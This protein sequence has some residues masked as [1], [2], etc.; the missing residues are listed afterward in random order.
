MFKTF[1]SDGRKIG[2]PRPEAVQLGHRVL[3]HQPVRHHDF[4]QP[5][6]GAR[7]KSQ[8]AAD[9]EERPLRQI[10]LEGEKQ[11]D[12]FFQNLRAEV[13]PLLFHIVE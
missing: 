8:F 2:Q 5:A 10:G 4:Q 11:L 12:R 6:R 1:F 9:V 13:F 7:R 3:L